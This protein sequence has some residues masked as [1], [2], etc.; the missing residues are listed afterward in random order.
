MRTISENAADFLSKLVPFVE[1]DGARNWNEISREMPIPYMTLS[2]RMVKLKED[3]FN[4]LGI[5]DFDK[6]GLERFRVF[7]KLM[8][9][10]KEVKPFFGG[11]HQSAGLKIYSRSMDTHMFDCEFAIPAGTLPQLRKL[12]D[13]LVDLKIIQNVEVRRLLWKDLLML[14]TQFYD[15]SKKEWDVDFSALTGD[16]SIEIPTKSEPQKFDYADLLM[17]KELEPDPWIKT[18]ELAKK[19]GL[20]KGDAIYH[21]NKHVFGKKLIKSFK[22][23]WWGNKEVWMKHSIILRTYIFKEISSEDARH[24]M[25]ILTS[26]PFTWSHMMTEDGMYMAEMMFP[27]IQFSEA[28]QYISDRL[29]ESNLSPWQVLHKDWSCLST[30]TIPYMLYNNERS[31][32]EFNADYALD[33]TL[34][35]IKTYSK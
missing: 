8:I 35:M 32:W 21:L 19:M 24:A 27:L 26:A 18:V 6:L 9:Q 3:G 33:Y 30:F 29:R 16:P 5:P 15:Y 1:S 22:L 34:Q 13:K 28:S 20:Q 7:F 12:L 17:I 10:A 23:Y 4:L 31:R 2:K 11:L 14:K 25:S